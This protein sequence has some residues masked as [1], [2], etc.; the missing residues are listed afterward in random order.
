MTGLRANEFELAAGVH[1]RHSRLANELIVVDEVRSGKVVVREL[2]DGSVHS[3]PAADFLRLYSKGTI[4]PIPAEEATLRNSESRPPGATEKLPPI[5]GLI[6][7]K[8]PAE[9]AHGR[10][11]L[12]YREKLLSEFSDLRPTAKIKQRIE[13]IRMERG[14]AKAPTAWTIYKCDLAITEAGGNV[15]VAYPNFRERG[16]GGKCRL[17]MRTKDAL[18][19]ALVEVRKSKGRILYSRVYEDVERRL[20]GKYDDAAAELRPAYSTVR[21]HVDAVIDD[22]EMV[23]RN[24]GPKQAERE[25]AQWKRRPKAMAPLQRFECDDKNTGIFGVCAHSGLPTGRI[26]IS[27]VLD[28][29]TRMSMGHLVLGQTPNRWSALN[30]LIVAIM[31]KDMSLP[32]MK[33]VKSEVPYCGLPARAIFDNALQNHSQAIDGA[34]IEY[35]NI[36]TA[37]AKPYAPRQKSNVEGHFNW[38]VKDFL[39]DLPGFVGPKLSRDFLKDARDRATATL[40][41]Y[42]QLYSKWVYDVYANHPGEDGLSPLQRWSVG[43]LNTRPRFPADVAR[44]RVAA[45]P[46]E[47]RKLRPGGIEFHLLIY[48]HDRLDDLVTAGFLGM[49]VLLKY[50]PCD[51]GTLWFKDPLSKSDEWFPAESDNPE[52][53]AGLTLYQHRTM[54]R[55]ARRNKLYNPAR[56]QWLNLK[57]EL[58][59]MVRKLR[60][61]T[62]ITERAKA[63]TLTIS[64]SS[65]TQTVVE[66]VKMGALEAALDDIR[67]EVQD[68]M[69]EQDRMHHLE[70]GEHMWTFS[71]DD[72]D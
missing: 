21:R 14:D 57:A 38:M 43:M 70:L 63:R 50:D 58:Q 3:I 62:S 36:G 5:S 30:T 32:S 28:Q 64:D 61:S 37:Y 46:V 16:G 60:N 23:R 13:E 71:D 54:K 7:D 39:A 69:T 51:L 45:M 65:E 8:S 11:K 66:T 25:F 10:K 6:T 20:I 24:K 40:E 67:E 19:G 22:Y 49:D 56:K 35:G 27:V 12:E 26:W 18:T 52:Y 29:N 4:L 1:F 41:E 42:D 33:H 47:M 44:M 53:T 34:I 2:S 59:E 15:A 68:E 31:P 17:D 55:I 48:V 72:D 9:L